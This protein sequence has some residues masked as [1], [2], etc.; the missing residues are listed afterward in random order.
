MGLYLCVFRDD[1][2]LFGIDVGSYDDW[3]RF[4]GEARA[5]DGR[6]FRRYG[7][8]RVHV[9]PTTHWSP[10]DA[11]RLAGELAHLREALRRE[12][13]R[14]LPPGSWQA[15]LAAERGLAP[16]TLADC[17]FDVDGVPLFDGLAELCRLAVETRQPI[18]F[19]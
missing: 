13:P 3:E 5:R 2:E 16:A 19:Q 14:P 7:A 8:L 6:I 18:L 9:S 12:P 10:R 11:A 15:E 17:F 1:E 4:R